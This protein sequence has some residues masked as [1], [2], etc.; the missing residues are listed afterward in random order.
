[1]VSEES[2]KTD[3]APRM[4]EAEFMAELAALIK[5]GEE[6]GLSPLTLGARVSFRRGV[7]WFDGIMADLE[8]S[9]GSGKKR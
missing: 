8:K 1:M 3:P 6:A 5:R 4:T 2:L 9:I 7:S